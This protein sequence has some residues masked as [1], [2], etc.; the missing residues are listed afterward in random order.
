MKKVLSLFLSLIMLIS[1]AAGVDF[2]AYAGFESNAKKVELNTTY[3][4]HYSKSD[5][6]TWTDNYSYQSYYFTLPADG[7]LTVK[8]EAKSTGYF[9]YEEDIYSSAD[10]NNA[11][12][13]GN[14]NQNVKYDYDERTYYNSIS[15]YLKKGSYYFYKEYCNAMFSDGYYT[16]TYDITFSFK[17]DVTKPS[18]LKVYSRGTTSLKLSWGKVS[19]VSG[20]QL[21]QKSGD[22]WKTKLTTS[23]TSATISKLTAGKTY[24]FRVRSYK[25]I[26]GKK[27]YSSWRT[28]TTCTKPATVKLSSLTAYS[29]HKIKASWKKVSGYASGYQVYWAKDK[30]FKNI[31]AKTTV[32]G[33]SKTSYTGKNFTK[34]KRYYVKVRAYKTLNGTKYYGAWSNVKSIVCK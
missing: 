27:Y 12:W 4:N 34:G 9:C 16:G 13:S 22:S 28:L 11:I 8:I 14:H 18:S 1:I 15:V 7:T 25:T 17:V 5:P 10:I 24:S 3:T 31:V 33:Q 30:N 19:G 26:N 21:Q 2:S 20:Y 32:S 29:N 6:L 23:S